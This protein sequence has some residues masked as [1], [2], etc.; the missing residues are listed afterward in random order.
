MTVAE[1]TQADWLP[2]GTQLLFLGTVHGDPRGFRRLHGFLERFQ[3]D[4]ILVE[5]SPLGWAFRK[6]HHQ[7]LRKTLRDNLRAASL[8]AG[9]TW[10][11][12]LAHPEVQAIE[13]QIALPFEYR[14]SDRYARTHN[15]RRLLVDRS[16]VS[17]ELIAHWTDLLSTS[18]LAF[19]LS[20]PSA[21]KHNLVDDH[22][23]RAHRRLASPFL[24]PQHPRPNDPDPDEDMWKAR[25]CSL[26]ER[27]RDIVVSMAPKLAVY[28][29]GWEHLVSRDDPPSLRH[30]LGVPAKHC[31]LLDDFDS[32]PQV[33]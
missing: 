16:D 23:Q 14:A 28:V 21:R 32:K 25:E 2:K 15:K 19:L 20:L 12:A 7:V 9:W 17:Q 11:E 6:A 5:L 30:L 4:L 1:V 27:V 10:R 8:D 33:P 18:N 26:A 29:G 22:Y 3:P 13:R 31:F 24:S